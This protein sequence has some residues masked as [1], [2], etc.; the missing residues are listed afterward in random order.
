M[1]MNLQKYLTLFIGALAFL[2]Q[3]SYAQDAPAPVVKEKKGRPVKIMYHMAPAGAPTE[4]TIYIGKKQVA[5]TPL[6]TTNFSETFTIPKGEHR[7]RFLPA[8]IAEDSPL[9]RGT[10]SVH[11]PK[12][13]QKVL[14]LVL[15]DKSN[16]VMPIKLRAIDASDGRFGNSSILMLNYSQVNVFGFLGDKKIE[17]KPQSSLVVKQP[18]SGNGY[19]PVKLQ[20]IVAKGEKPRRFIRQM[21]SNDDTMRNVVFILPKP[22]PMYAT[23]YSAPIRDF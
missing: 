22:A 5:K 6:P 7:L 12:R 9:P 17:L 4:T 21:W 10:P 16:P 20:S 13:W 1:K 19:Y 18:I 3:T 8:P 14:I 15:T 11:I 23:Y 2:C